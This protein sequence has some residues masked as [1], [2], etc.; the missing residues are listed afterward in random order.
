M[1]QAAD[2]AA[3][4][5]QNLPQAGDQQQ[6]N[7]KFDG[8]ERR[9]RLGW[10]AFWRGGGL[11]QQPGRSGCAFKENRR[12][13][14]KKKECDGPREIRKVERMNRKTGC[15]GDEEVGPKTPARQSRITQP[16]LQISDPEDAEKRQAVLQQQRGARAARMGA[17]EAQKRAA[18]NGDQRQGEQK[19]YAS[20][21]PVQK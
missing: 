16:P 21:L 15:E 20:H 1:G 6:E 4:Q 7:R 10:F 8:P 17:P 11:G 14:E 12:K 19:S 3:Q 18:G 9:N 2:V 5:M 13:L